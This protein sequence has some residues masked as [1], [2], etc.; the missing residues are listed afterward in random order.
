M[1]GRHTTRWALPLFR[2]L[3]RGFAARARRA[4]SL[5]DGLR[6]R[7][8]ES[9]KQR[10][11]GRTDV[12]SR[13][14][15]RPPPGPRNTGGPPAEFSRPTG[16]LE[17]RWRSI[18]TPGPHQDPPPRWMRAR[19]AP[20]RRRTVASAAG[21]A[22]EDPPFGIGRAEPPGGGRL[23]SRALQG[24]RGRR[25]R[26]HPGLLA[27][28]SV[29]SASLARHGPRHRGRPLDRGAPR[30]WPRLTQGP[31][32]FRQ[33]GEP[34]RRASD[35]VRRA[36]RAGRRGSAKPTGSAPANSSES[37]D[38]ELDE[39]ATHLGGRLAARRLARAAVIRAASRARS[40]PQRPRPVG[41]DGPSDLGGPFDL[42]PPTFASAPGDWPRTRARLASHRMV[43]GR[44]GSPRVRESTGG[45][46]MAES[47]KP[48]VRVAH[49]QVATGAT[50]GGGRFQRQAPHRPARLVT[51]AAGASM[52]RWV[53]TSNDDTLS[54]EDLALGL[55]SMLPARR[56]VAGAR[57][58][59][60]LCG[61]AGRSS[62]GE[63]WRIPGAPV[64][65]S[66]SLA[67]L[68]ERVAEI[69][70]GD[71]MAQLSSPKT[72]TRSRFVEVR[73]R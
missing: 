44:H 11:H 30:G 6:K 56:A 31:C 41:L 60:R 20:K 35:A 54:V 27:P 34:R 18:A 37:P 46:P 39:P 21:R 66:V 43:G 8:P 28:P 47:P 50:C 53:I 12:P 40:R 57:L 16:P 4:R 72:R 29:S 58:Q 24:G 49:Q 25:A 61:M 64:T 67:L 48:H 26:W 32:F 69:R 52:A 13:T 73:P 51:E 5:S 65:I 36:G 10:P 38:I 70:D 22:E 63:P 45:A 71:N 9:P 59:E 33:P 17:S 62:T 2:L 42:P 1:R 15:Q 3:R 7:Q 68:L 55:T 23:V 14:G 19:V